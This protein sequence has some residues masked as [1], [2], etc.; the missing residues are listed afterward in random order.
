MVAHGADG[1]EHV[2][3]EVDA[4]LAVLIERRNRLFTRIQAMFHAGEDR[5]QHQIG[6]GVGAGQAVFD[7]QVFA[8]RFG[9]A[10]AC[11]AVLIPP[12]GTAGGVDH[13]AVAAEGVV[14]S[15]EDRHAVRQQLQ[16]TGHGVAQRALFVGGQQVVAGGVI[17]ADV[18]MH[19]AAR[20]LQVGL[21]H[22]AGA[23]AVLE[24]HATGAAAEQ[25]GPVGGA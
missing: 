5:R 9:N 11:I 12:T 19:A 1:A 13:G 24:R 22:K 2:L 20:R 23:L 25:G 15:G 10:D 18:H 6:V 17:Q 3:R 4:A 7:A 21:A 16:A 8:V 14:V